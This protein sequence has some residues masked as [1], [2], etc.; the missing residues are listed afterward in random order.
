MLSQFLTDNSWKNCLSEEFSKD[1]FKAF[2]SFVENEYKTQK[3]IYP[4]RDKIFEALNL[5]PL[6]RVRAVILG[7]DPYHGPT[8]AHGLSFSVR[9]GVRLPPSLKNIFQEL[10]DSL[11]VN[12]P[13]HGDLTPWAK[14]GVL[15]L[16]C[17]LT[18]EKDKPG[19]HQKKGWEQF[20]DTIIRKINEKSQPVAFV[21]WGNYAQN[22]AKDI[23]NNRHLILKSPHPSP[24]SSYRGFFGSQPFSKIN[25]FLEKTG[26]K[27]ID[28]KL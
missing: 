15:L 23:D 10:A 1:Y 14:Q 13:L 2:S 20:T 24:L 6:P 11:K 28:W 17:I 12:L 4:P 3:I 25:T 9:E 26:Q 16:N 22:K 7:Q 5:T 21:L 18:V 19:S 27:P 8:Q